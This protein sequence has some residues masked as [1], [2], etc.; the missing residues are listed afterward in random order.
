MSRLTTKKAKM[1]EEIIKTGLVGKSAYYYTL[2]DAG[3]IEKV[4][5]GSSKREVYATSEEVSIIK[6]N[7]AHRNY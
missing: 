3:C 2:T 6:N 7:M 5:H 4:H 1:I